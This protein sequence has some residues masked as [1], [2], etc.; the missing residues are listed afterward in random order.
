[1]RPKKLI[2]RAYRE[3]SRLGLAVWRADEAGPDPGIP[4]PGVSWQPRGQPARYPH[5]YLRGGTA[6]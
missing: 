2:E 3:G 5:E 4:Q 1:P 6:K